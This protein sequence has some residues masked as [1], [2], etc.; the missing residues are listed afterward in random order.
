MLGMRK[1]NVVRAIR[2]SRLEREGRRALASRSAAPRALPRRTRPTASLHALNIECPRK[3]GEEKHELKRA[4]ARA[5]WVPIQSGQTEPAHS[6]S[7][8]WRPGEATLN[9]SWP[10]GT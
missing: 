6:E 1:L 3:D 10:G 4:K 5:I 2:A 8:F 7:G 9:Y